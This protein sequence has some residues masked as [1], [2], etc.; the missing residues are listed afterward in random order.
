M[1]KSLNRCILAV[2]CIA[3]VCALGLSLLFIG[4][5]TT[6]VAPQEGQAA[7]TA[8]NTNTYTHGSYIGRSLPS[9]YTSVSNGTQLKAAIE[10]NNKDIVLTNDVTLQTI[11]AFEAN[12][13]LW[14]DNSQCFDS[15]GY[16]NQNLKVTGFTHKIYGQGHTIE[17]QGPHAAT[18]EGMQ[19]NSTDTNDYGGLFPKLG[20]N[21]AV[22]DVRIHITKGFS[23]QTQETFSG[24]LSSNDEWLNVGGIAG[25]LIGNA[26]IDNVT[27]EIA[28]GVK[29]ASYKWSDGSST[30]QYVRVGAI[31]G[32]IN[33]T[34]SISNVTVINNG[35]L[36][37]GQYTSEA[38]FSP[39]SDRYYG[40]AG[41]VV[42]WISNATSSIHNVR[43]EGSGTL[44][45]YYVAN[46]ANAIGSTVSVN[47][48]YNNFTGTFDAKYNYSNTLGQGEGA[49]STLTVTNHYKK[50]ALASTAGTDTTVGATNTLTV[51]NNLTLYFIPNAT[52]DSNRLGI[53]FSGTTYSS[54]NDYSVTGLNNAEKTASGGF[55]AAPSGGTLALG[56]PVGANNWKTDGTFA[57]ITATPKFDPSSYAALTKYEHGYVS[58]RTTNSGTPI[59]SDNFSTYFAPGGQA[60]NQSSTYYLTQ[61]IVVTG[62][63]GINFSGTF[64][65]NGHTIFIVAN[66]TTSGSAVGGLVGNMTGGTIKNL[67]VVIYNSVNVGVN[68]PSS[69]VAKTQNAVGGLVGKMSGGSLQNVQV[70]IQSGATMQTSASNDNHVS[71]GGVVGQITST[72]SLTDVTL[73]LDGTISASGRY[74]FTGGIV[75]SINGSAAP[76]FT[77]IIMRGNGT[78]ASTASQGEDPYYAAVGILENSNGADAAT[79]TLDGFIYDANPNFTGNYGMY[80]IFTNNCYNSGND[81][82]IGNYHAYVDY[83]NI[84][85][86]D[87]SGSILDEDNT[88]HQGGNAIVPIGDD[89]TVKNIS[90]NVTGVAGS[91]VKAYFMPNVTGKNLALVATPPASGWVAAQKLQSNGTTPELSEDDTITTPG[92]TYKVVYVAKDNAADSENKVYLSTYNPYTLITATL[93]NPS[94]VYDGNPYVANVAFT[95]ADGSGTSVTIDTN[96]Y[97]ITYGADGAT[98]ETNAGSYNV[99]I[100]LQDTAVD[101]STGKT[102]VFENNTTSTTIQYT[103]TKKTVSLASNLATTLGGTFG[104]REYTYTTGNKYTIT[105]PEGVEVFDA[106]SLDG[107]T[108]PTDDYYIEIVSPTDNIPTSGGLI[109]AGTYSYNVQF[110][111]AGS[112]NYQFS[113]GSGV[114][115]ISGVTVA[116]YALTGT[117]TLSG[118]EITYGD[119]IPDYDQYIRIELSNEGTIPGG[120]TG[121]TANG[122]TADYVQGTTQAGE[123]VT[124]TAGTFTVG[125]GFTAS[126]YN[127]SG[128]SGITGGGTVEVQ[129]REITISAADIEDPAVGHIVAIYGGEN[130]V[131]S[132]ESLAALLTWANIGT[133]V[134]GVYVTDTIT[135]NIAAVAHEQ[136]GEEATYAPGEPVQDGEWAKLP[137][138]DTYYITVTSANNNYT[139]AADNYFKYQVKP[140]E[141]SI[142]SV[143]FDNGAESTITYDGQDHNYTVNTTGLVEGDTLKDVINVSVTYNSASHSG[144]MVNAGTYTVTVELKQEGGNYDLQIDVSNTY[145][146]TILPITFTVQ[147]ASAT[148]TQYT[149]SNEA[150]KVLEDMIV[151]GDTLP[152][153]VQLST[154][155]SGEISYPNHSGGYLEVTS[156]GYTVNFA[157]KTGYTTNY[158]IAGADSATLTINP[159]NL[160]NATIEVNPGSNTY[161]Y[162]GKTQTVPVT[163]TTSADDGRVDIVGFVTISGNEKKNAGVNYPVTVSGNSSNISGEQ[164]T[165]GTWSIAK[166]T[167]TIEGTDALTSEYSGEAVAPADLL[168]NTYITVSGAASGEDVYSMLTA[169]SADGEILNYKE[170]GYTV[171]IALGEMKEGA[172]NYQIS[173]G[174]V[175]VTYTVTKKAVT[176]TWTAEDIVFGSADAP[177]AKITDFGGILEKDQNCTLLTTDTYESTMAVGTEVTYTV[178]TLSW[179][180]E[181]IQNNYDITYDP[182]NTITVHVVSPEVEIDLTDDP[183]TFT[184]IYGYTTVDEFLSK[185]TIVNSGGTPTSA[186]YGVT[187]TDSNSQPVTLNGERLDVGTYTVTITSTQYQPTGDTSYT[188]EVEPYDLSTLGLTVTVND[189][190]LVYTGEKLS[191]IVTV[192]VDGEDITD[193]L[194]IGGNTAT[195]VSATGYT[196][197]VSAGSNTNFTGT[198]SFDGTWNIAP[199]PI[200]IAGVE[201]ALTSVYDGAEIAVSTL[202][203]ENYITVEG[204]AASFTYSMLTATVQD[205]ATVQNADN[206]TIIITL[207][208]E[209]QG[210]GN[211]TIEG[212]SATVTYTVTPATLTVAD[213]I[214]KTFGDIK[215]GELFAAIGSEAV[216]GMVNDEDLSGIVEMTTTLGSVEW[217]GE[218]YYVAAASGATVTVT[219]KDSNYTFAGSAKEAGVTLSIV[220]L[221]DTIT[222]SETKTAYYYDV[223]K[224]DEAT[225]SDNFFTVSTVSGLPV[226][227]TYY[228]GG[229]GSSPYDSLN[230]GDYISFDVTSTNIAVINITPTEDELSVNFNITP[231][232]VTYTVVARPVNVAIDLTDVNPTY[233]G[234]AFSIPNEA[235]TVTDSDGTPS[236]ADVSGQILVLMQGASDAEGANAVVNAGAYTVSA[237]SESSN[238]VINDTTF[239]GDVNTV[240]IAPAAIDV[241]LAQT[242]FTYGDTIDLG[243]TVTA[244]EGTDD[245]IGVQIK[246]IVMDGA[247]DTGATVTNFLNAGAGTYFVTFELTGDD[248]ANYELSATSNPATVTINRKQVTITWAGVDGASDNFTYTYDGTAKV[249]TASV[250]GAVDESHFTNINEKVTIEGALTDEKAINAG[251]Y[252]ATITKVAFEAQYDNYTIAEDSAREFVIDPATISVSLSA[253]GGECV[254]GNTITLNVFGRVT[255]SEFTGGQATLTEGENTVTITAAAADGTTLP[256]IF[257]TLNGEPYL[258]TPYGTKVESDE[259]SVA[260]ANANYKLTVEQPLT[261][262][263][264]PSIVVQV[265][266]EALKTAEYNYSKTYSAGDFTGYFEVVGSDGTAVTGGSGAVTIAKDG[267]PVT[268]PIVDAGDYTITYTYTPENWQ[269]NDEDKPST[270]YTFTITAAQ[271]SDVTLGT[272][273]YGELSATGTITATITYADGNS[274]RAELSYTAKDITAGDGKTIT[275]GAYTNDDTNYAGFERRDVTVTIAP[276]P[277][278]VEVTPEY[279]SYRGVE[280]A[281]FGTITDGV[282]GTDEVSV[283]VITTNNPVRDAG[284]YTITGITLTGAAASNYT[285]GSFTKSITIDKHEVTITVTPNVTTTTPTYTGSKIGLAIS[286]SKWMG[287]PNNVY[288][289][290]NGENAQVADFGV[291]NAGTYTVGIGG[292]DANNYMMSAASTSSFTI[293]KAEATLSIANYATINGQEYNGQRVTITPV[294]TVGGE[295]LPTAG[296]VEVSIN[297]KTDYPGTATDQI[298]YAGEYTVTLT[299]DGNNNIE[300]TSVNFT[301]TI[302]KKAVS[303]ITDYASAYSYDGTAKDLNERVAEA[304]VIGDDVV[305]ATVDSIVDESGTTVTE[306]KNAGTYTVTF[307]LS[308]D[309]ARNY[310]IEEE[311]SSMTVTINP[312]RVTVTV[313]PASDTYTGSNIT[314]NGTINGKV[315]GDEVSATITTTVRN[316]TT[317]WAA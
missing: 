146:L 59:T 75:G 1:S 161:T 160:A 245:V 104:E 166:A 6:V 74:V 89:T 46:I 204:A 296:I 239:E 251:S 150:A 246:N 106:A 60:N 215:E 194:V 217:K 147:D 80:G 65:G 175:S 140:A 173:G 98:G 121:V 20:K 271:V 181:D 310:V 77:N 243:A 10:A 263:I 28:S 154:V 100:T 111:S 101:S 241:T 191:P 223:Y 27:V 138:N 232:R 234:T 211:Y 278:T 83:E 255:A 103:I 73:Q 214:T 62:F 86:M 93:Q 250:V 116:P 317:P 257:F 56:L 307:G 126:N 97:T 281:L 96:S 64:D 183:T 303:V 120:L 199:K 195:D 47:N 63:T 102:Y 16:G 5:E 87:G 288:V 108:I 316:A 117:W 91:A 48:F 219:I 244:I 269:G 291:V 156:G 235:V 51:P 242:E 119:P 304:E 157:I 253:S 132:Q 115:G 145:T 90:A 297:D 123:T 240:T 190:N 302:A 4:G 42:G 231:Q 52:Q 280:I 35:R 300:D 29:L 34:A 13:Y 68:N 265:K 148:F 287:V 127:F 313:T 218:S 170:G 41:N 32:E 118:L 22:Y 25:S 134:K 196:V 92:T 11:D 2:V 273:T 309:N 33:N 135:F 197:T 163:V 58:S 206:Y 186:N 3:L 162:N 202:I 23:G 19:Q 36:E 267:E 274:E 207:N 177:A 295:S 144:A 299:V 184:Y 312:A 131:K 205:G 200:T 129:Q 182:A 38:K 289:T 294:M 94:K 258:G 14:N 238:V 105:I 264:N 79:A 110:T 142:D 18:G 8:R 155:V 249:P 151:A 165:A 128:I 216:T 311:Y 229:D 290:V 21:G 275:L 308:G 95:L 233:T 114:E 221:D 49:T 266:D 178:S 301:V 260:T 230:S 185:F 174:P 167:I 30:S 225:G 220:K 226:Q 82:N 149:A 237:K 286:V 284:T 187:I 12:N 164:R 143:T 76:K 141:L 43:V 67:R 306:L 188:Y 122:F 228:N 292:S 37:S 136:T 247:E 85:Y 81:S 69:S 198:P 208:A 262:N 282:F 169:T 158:A 171:N 279:T 298:L 31:A 55:S 88:K 193:L 176:V 24:M 159:Y 7:S 248:A 283:G 213:S 261:L 252:T 44:Y 189:D 50:G 45:S 139:V 254:S 109:P 314:V 70:V 315:E 72:V 256:D 168:S 305:T 107:L 78:F 133:Y 293:A 66:N 272:I 99:T 180:N 227:I 54:A 259:L 201:G 192:M 17:V 236:H 172:S 84:F 224:R 268:E 124:I 39:D 222:I 9:D 53:A 285:V 270:S 57:S 153:G 71:I 210:S 203:A 26:V 209:E 113:S 130:Y 61:D 152:D 112:N 137:A 277:V 212:G 15:D 40:A 125:S 276:A 179:D